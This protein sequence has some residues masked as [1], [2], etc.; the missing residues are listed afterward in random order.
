MLAEVSSVI[1][2]DWQSLNYC[3]EVLHQGSDS[4]KLSHKI[5]DSKAAPVPA[6][7]VACDGDDPQRT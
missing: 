1:K 3:F 5:P 7:G 4:E 2:Q 6:L